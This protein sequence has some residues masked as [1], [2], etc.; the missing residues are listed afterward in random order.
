[1]KNGFTH[2]WNNNDVTIIEY[3]SISK[4]TGITLKHV[5]NVEIGSLW[6]QWKFGNSFKHKF[7]YFSAS[8]YQGQS[9]VK[10]ELDERT[11]SNI[12]YRE[13][14]CGAYIKIGVTNVSHQ[15]FS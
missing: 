10:L 2:A 5:I 9:Q 6:I 11:F 8:I 14:F 1:M 13:L 3:S 15:N 4:L 7:L 12:F